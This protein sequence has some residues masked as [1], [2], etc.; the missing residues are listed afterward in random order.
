MR[1]MLRGALLAIILV[2][3][4]A[5]GTAA[6][7]ES[8]IKNLEDDVADLHSRIVAL[9]NAQALIVEMQATPYEPAGFFGGVAVPR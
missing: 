9:E 8:R 4:T 7:D 5:A 6:W 1:N 2:A 3:C